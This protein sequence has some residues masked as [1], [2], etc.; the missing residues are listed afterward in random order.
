MGK[1]NLIRKDLADK[2]CK[3]I[4][5][6]K[7]VSL[8]IVDDL[9]ETLISELVKLNNIKISSFGTFKVMQK[10]ERLGRNPK[11]K[12]EAKIIARKVVSFKPSLDT[13]NKLNKW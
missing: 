9:F 5:F 13:K 8:T 7:S 1:K 4:G 2:V 6:S 11:T 3:K 10:K 12:V